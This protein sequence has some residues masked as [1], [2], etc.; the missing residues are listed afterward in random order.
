[1]AQLKLYSKP[2]T[3]L[4]TDAIGILVS[5]GYEFTTAGEQLNASL[6]GKLLR[7]LKDEDFRVKARNVS[8]F[9]SADGKFKK[10]LSSSLPGARNLS[11]LREAAYSCVRRALKHGVKTLALAMD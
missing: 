1:M 9:Y 8:V 6:K 10:V 5:G 3:T 7:N 11:G 4:K 2:I